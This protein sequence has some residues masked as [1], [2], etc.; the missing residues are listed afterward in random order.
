MAGFEY[1]FADEG[2]FRTRPKCISGP[3]FTETVVLGTFHGSSNDITG[4]IQALRGRFAP[5]SYNL[6]RQNCN[7][8]SDALANDLVGTGIPSHLNRAADIGASVLP[9]KAFQVGGSSPAAGGDT[10]PKESSSLW[11]S[12]VASF[13]TTTSSS[14]SSSSSWLTSGG[15]SQQQPAAARKKKE[16]TPQQKDLLNRVRTGAA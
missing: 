12:F 2:V 16:L 4:V 9:S 11:T 5:G 1:T 6:V 15:G 3:R 10:T 8:F 7:H 13:S 14:S